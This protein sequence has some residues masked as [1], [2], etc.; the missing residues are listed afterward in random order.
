MAKEV[1]GWLGHRIL[2]AQK[3]MAN[4]PDWMKA[5]ARFE[6][7]HNPGNVESKPSTG[8]QSEEITKKKLSA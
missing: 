7:S 8:D 5:S 2:E 4:W 1:K 6:G 3:E